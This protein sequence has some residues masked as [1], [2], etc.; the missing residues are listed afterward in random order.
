MRLA[1]LCV[2]MVV[3]I[4]LPV[5]GEPAAGEKAASKAP[6]LETG[7]PLTMEDCVLIALKQNPQITSSQQGII[8]AQAGLTRARSSYY[9]QVSLDMTEGFV[10][11]TSA[12][13]NGGA[14][15]FA[16]ADT[17]QQLDLGFGLTFWQRGREESVAQRR[18]S[19]KSA[20]QSLASTAQSLTEQ[21]AGQYLNVL[22]AQE[23]VGVAQ[24]GVGSAQAHLEQVKARAALGA[25]AEVD[26]FPAEDDLARAQLDLIDARSNVRL[27][28]AQL[29]NAMAVP[30]ETKFDLAPSPAPIKG[31]I[32]VFQEAMRTALER[33]PEVAGSRH[34]VVASRYA[35]TQAKIRRGPLV[36]VAGQYGQPYTDWNAHEGTWS[37]L[38]GLSW[39]LFD[40][41]ATQSDVTSARATLTRTQA[42][43]QRQVNQVGLEVED[44]LVEVERSQ[45]RLDA[46]AKSVAAADA[47]L[48]AA[49]GKY[50]QGVGIL[51]EVIDARVAVTTASANQVRARY[52]YQVAL[53]GLQKATGTLPVP[54]TGG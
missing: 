37:L 54:R 42:D 31:A 45:E 22:A 40:G 25:T 38:L 3:F 13:S 26:V 53:I 29:K 27:A 32:P 35:L 7:K 52:D 12:A 8:T 47:R 28:F 51:L 23:L 19:L 41:R 9:P 21:V 39:P 18:A 15:T 30:Q 17:L 34:D 20:E 4:A 36:D 5:P 44:A 6:A 50:R 24:G 46:T 48:R 49:E 14:F 33:R 2:I 10:S 11:E 43:L 1:L 16:P